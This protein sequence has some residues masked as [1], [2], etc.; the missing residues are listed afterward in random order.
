H[1]FQYM[2]YK[3]LLVSETG[4]MYEMIGRKEM[5]PFLLG[6]TALT[7]SRT[8]KLEISLVSQNFN[9]GSIS[10]LEKA[11][12]MRGMVRV[13]FLALLRS[14]ISMRGPR[15]FR[16]VSS[17]LLSLLRTYFAPTPRSLLPPEVIYVES[18]KYPQHT[19]YTITTDDGA[20]ISCWRWLPTADT[21]NENA[22][23]SGTS[24]CVLL[25]NGYS[26]ESYTLPTEENDLVRTLLN[27]GYEVWLLRMRLHF[28]VCTENP[29]SLDDIARFDLPAGIFSRTTFRS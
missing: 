8:L 11:A 24:T 9:S 21:S 22:P 15:R 17:L 1:P 27:K 6:A 20:Q 5:K 14:M 18:L 26:G 28:S 2:Y 3:L 4:S 23:D 10:G 16:F 7:E 29:F 12:S 19:V 25:L 13:S